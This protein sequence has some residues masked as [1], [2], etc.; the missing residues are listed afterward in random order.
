MTDNNETLA[1]P[2]NK[3][4]RPKA[5]KKGAYLWVQSEYVDVIKALYETM[6]QQNQQAKP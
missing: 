1:K 5:A 2:K 3:G 6:K 4:G